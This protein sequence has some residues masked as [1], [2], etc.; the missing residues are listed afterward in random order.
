MNL[1]HLNTAKSEFLLSI[2]GA[3]AVK[4][5]L[6]EQ[7]T[8]GSMK[9]VKLLNTKPLEPF[10][11]INK[12]LY[13]SEKGARVSKIAD[14]TKADEG[15]VLS[16]LQILEKYGLARQYGTKGAAYWYFAGDARELHERS[17]EAMKDVVRYG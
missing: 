5:E 15:T 1:E 7:N 2:I 14:A 16:H 3:N 4:A 6:F 13:K 9:K 8:G 10:L 17:V 12:F 11:S